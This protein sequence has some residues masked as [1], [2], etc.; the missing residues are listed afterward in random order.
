[1]GTKI[2]YLCAMDYQ[3]CIAYLY[4]KLPMF[5]RTGSAA[6]KMDLSNTQRIC[7][8]LGNPENS[9]KTIHIAGTNGKGSVSHM[10]AS[11]LQEQ[12]Y[13]T[14][15]YTSPHLYDFRERIRIN[16][17]MIPEDRVIAFTQKMIPLIESI[18]PSFFEVT[19]GMAFDHFARE[20][21]DFAIIET[22]LGGRLDSTNV[23]TP[24]L[25]IITNIGFDHMSILGNTLSKIASEKAGI[26]K[27]GVPVVIGKKDPETAPV[28]VHQAE[29]KGAPLTFAEDL[30]KTVNYS[31]TP[32]CIQVI[33]QENM[34][35]STKTYRSPLAGI[36]Q[37]ENIRTVISG[38]NTLASQNILIKEDAIERGI[39]AVIHNTGLHGRWEMVQR[40][41]SIILDVAHNPA[42]IKAL[43]EQL[44]LTPYKNLFIILG[45][46]Q[47]K[48]VDGILGLLPQNAY[49][50]FTQANL[51]RALESNQLA[52]KAMAMGL[53]GRSYAN[54]N[55]AMENFISMADDEDLIVVCG[56]IF[57]VGEVDRTRFN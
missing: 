19:V 21:V 7:E 39:S 10:L 55:L 34:T 33:L 4:T 20:K 16:G 23:I 6:L 25:S 43:T 41:P 38:I 18:E 26:I 27:S 24:L 56:S 13:K 50:G 40:K 12:G 29:Q 28:F 44:T 32:G 47:D 30:Y 49:Y 52:E 37:S 8:A 9:V 35:S 51:P 45:V 53:K 15:L 5:S 1:M 54:V 31:Y 42:G 46:S 3:D 17:T 22:G 36:Y 48:D 14:G 11:I 2:Q 57:I